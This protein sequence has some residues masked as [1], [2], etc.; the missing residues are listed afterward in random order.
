M[1]AVSRGLIIG[2]GFAGMSAAIELR[3]LGVEVDLVEIEPSSA[4]YGAGITVSGPSL[5]AIDRLGL[6][7]EFMARGACADGVDLFTVRGE[8]IHTLPT[9]RVAGEDVPGGGAILRPALASI[10]TDAALA[11]GARLRFG[12]TFVSIVESAGHVDVSFTDLTS[13]RY[14]LVVGADGLYS[15]TRQA[16]FPHAPEPRYTGQ[17]VWRA[18]APRGAVQRPAMYLGPR[19]KAGYNPVSR[20]ELYVFVTENRSTKMRLSPEQALPSLASLLAEFE[21]PEIQRLQ[22]GLCEQSHIVF[23]PLEALLMPQPWATGRVVLIGDTVHATTPHLASG[24]GLGIED[25]LVLAEEL[26][27]ASALCDALEAF[28]LRRWERC[29]RVVEDSSRLG[30]IELTNGSKAEHAQLMRESMAA[31]T[32][33][34]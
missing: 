16:L 18:L 33:P 32:A 6:L 28:Q 8:L 11:L 34:F 31:L 3:K 12:T 30:E 26:S 23:R 19:A 20:D 17:S 13:G 14:D 2:G 15:A 22:R 21:A 10:L 9:P 1:S 7:R 27:R 4:S 29:R 25:A 24:A 5:R